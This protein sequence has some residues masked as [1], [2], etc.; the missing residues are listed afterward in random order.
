MTLAA[1][2]YSR[3]FIS[4]LIVSA[5]LLS[6]CGGGGGNGDGATPAP[7]APPGNAS[8]HAMI[9]APSTAVSFGKV[10]LDGALSS[11]SDGQVTSYQW[12]Q[13]SGPPVT[14]VQGTNGTASF[15][16]P[17]SAG[18]VTIALTVSDNGGATG[19]ASSDVT[20]VAASAARSNV[21]L[22]SARMAFP[23][24]D[25]GHTDYS[26]SFGPPRADTTMLALVD[27]GGPVD[28]NVRFSLVNDAG[29]E[30]GVLN[31]QAVSDPAVQPATFA[32]EF[33]VPAQRFRIRATG[34]SRRGQ[35]FDVSST[36]FK[37]SR[38]NVRFD[39]S[40]VRGMIGATQS[41]KLN[42]TNS[43]PAGQ[44]TIHVIDSANAVGQP[45]DALRTIQTGETV[46]IDLQATVPAMA[47]AYESVMVEV[48]G[49][50]DASTSRLRI[51][52]E[53]AP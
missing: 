10:K 44:F 48:T 49:S 15:I 30:L 27:L 41:V 21:E 26:E 37:P 13:T 20:I 11:D 23:Q 9:S 17:E 38:L 42:I 53:V 33:T 1:Q 31:L 50:Q 2:F 51:W 34:T 40:A 19:S 39:P 45:V 25:G 29:N 4:C 28:E 22:I 6:A 32:G 7:P 46:S 18:T 8:P 35:Q 43:G 47:M 36:V 5:F 16:A 12:R 24:P 14:I 3:R 52:Q